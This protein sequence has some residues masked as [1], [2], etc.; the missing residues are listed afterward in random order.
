MHNPCNVYNMSLWYQNDCKCNHYLGTM[1]IPIHHDNFCTGQDPVHE[2][3]ELKLEERNDKL[4]QWN[5]TFPLLKKEKKM[6][7]KF[8]SLPETDNFWNIRIFLTSTLF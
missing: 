7:H 6:I 8:Q 2:E 5:V 3:L 1:Y 4:N